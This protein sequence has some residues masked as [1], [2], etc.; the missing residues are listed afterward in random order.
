[1]WRTGRQQEDLMDTTAKDARRTVAHFRRRAANHRKAARL[2]MLDCEMVQA[3]REVAR[4]L[5]LLDRAEAVLA[6]HCAAVAA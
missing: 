5:A 1:M 2:C 3:A 4:A 6:R